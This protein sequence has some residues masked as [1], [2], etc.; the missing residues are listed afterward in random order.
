MKRSR[1]NEILRES[2][3]FIRGH[4]VHLPP[5]AYFLPKICVPRTIQ[6]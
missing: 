4:G 2:D 3:A 5:F 1:I 6:R